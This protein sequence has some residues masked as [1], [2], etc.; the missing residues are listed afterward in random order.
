MIKAATGSAHHRPKAVLKPTLTRT[1]SD[2]HQHAVVLDLERAVLDAEEG[3]EAARPV[4]QTPTP[5]SQFAR[6]NNLVLSTGCESARMFVTGVASV[7][8]LR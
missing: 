1:A 2:S 4:S 8:A 3:G 6:L 7:G 5:A